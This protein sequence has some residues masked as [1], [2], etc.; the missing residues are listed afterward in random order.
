M[1][2]LTEC[3][4]SHNHLPHRSSSSDSSTD[5][6]NHWPPIIRHI[7]LGCSHLATLDDKHNINLFVS[8]EGKGTLWWPP[9][10]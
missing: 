8:R 6:G 1:A 4:S 2:I 3:G 10:E 5:A 9:D 7:L